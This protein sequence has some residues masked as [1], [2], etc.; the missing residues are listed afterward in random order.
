M[1]PLIQSTHSTTFRRH[2]FQQSKI[3]ASDFAPG[4]YSLV[5]PDVK[6][7]AISTANGKSLS[8][9]VDGSDVRVNHAKVIKTDVVCSN[10]IIHWVDTVMRP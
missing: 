7:M 5:N 10:G 6:T 1:P 9:K 2:K 3:L 4:A 8:A